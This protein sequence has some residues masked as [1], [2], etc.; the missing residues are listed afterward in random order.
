MNTQLINSLTSQQKYPKALDSVLKMSH[1]VNREEQQFLDLLDE[2]MTTGSERVDR[3]GI[4]T[5]AVFGRFLQFDL[6]NHI[7]PMGTTKPVPIRMVFEELMWFLRGET[8]STILEKKGIYVWKGNSSKEVLERHGLPYQEGDIGPTY[9]FNF[10]HYGAEYIDAQTNYTGKGVDQLDNVLQL[11][12]DDPFSRRI[13]INLW[14]P[15][16]LH[17]CPLPPCL[18]GYQFFVDIDPASGE[19]LLSCLMLQR[20]SDISLAGFWNIVTGS[21]LTLMVA[22]MVGMRPYTLKW[23]IGDAHI[24]NNQVD[25]VKEQLTRKPRR[26]PTVHFRDSAPSCSNNKQITEFVFEDLILMG[27]DP[28]PRIQSVLNV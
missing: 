5:K 14:N 21:L 23:S 8:D 18:F 17:Q 24:Y 7:L 19:R 11:L 13:L 12:R 26:F 15:H 27:Y 16:C 28:Y 10:R 9:G 22:R 20:S 2:I 6:S 1:P 25:A 4:G 3:T